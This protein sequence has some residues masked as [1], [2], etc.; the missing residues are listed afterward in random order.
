MTALW[1]QIKNKTPSIDS[2]FYLKS[3]PGK[4]NPDLI[5]NDGAS[6]CFEDSCPNK[7]KKNK[8]S[9]EL[10]IWDQLLIY[11]AAAAAEVKKLLSTHSIF[12]HDHSASTEHTPR[13]T[14]AL[15][16]V[17]YIE[18]TLL[19]LRL[20]GQRT[21][22]GRVPDDDVCIRTHR[23]TTL[24][25]VVFTAVIFQS[26]SGVPAGQSKISGPTFY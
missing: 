1:H 13:S 18:V 23:D 10:V 6:G 24:A 14:A 7:K 26:I 9:S 3:I 12:I 5:W 20:H 8:M 4:F 22:Y 2:L 25:T 21:G 11:S 19:M 16:T 17:K 15:Q